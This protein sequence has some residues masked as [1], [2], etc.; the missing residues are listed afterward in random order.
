[1]G[2]EQLKLRSTPPGVL[3]VQR[4]CQSCADAITVADRL[5]GDILMPN[6]WTVQRARDDE[7]LD[8]MCLGADESIVQHMLR[9]WEVRRGGG[10]MLTYD[11]VSCAFV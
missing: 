2:L 8:V 3:K 5:F 6:N 7:C 11:P 10:Q 1:M 9:L 4:E